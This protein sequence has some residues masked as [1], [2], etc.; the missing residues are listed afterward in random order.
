MIA[1]FCAAMSYCPMSQ[2]QTF[3]IRLLNAKS[4]K[5]M[6]NKNVTLIWGVQ[7]EV[8]VFIGKEGVGHA[9]IPPGATT[10]SMM[11]G[12]KIGN[13]PFRVAYFDCNDSAGKSPLVS[14]ALEK[15]FVPRN[16][17]GH[18]SVVPKPGEL[19]FWALPRPWWVPDF[20]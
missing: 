10:F 12:P 20:Q 15:G 1:L 18:K 9:A 11:E 8:E 5:A 13:E 2:S 19:I 16:T 6:Q 17:C 3:T 7:S 14:Q 4:G